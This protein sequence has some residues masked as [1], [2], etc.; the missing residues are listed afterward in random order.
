MD[1][2]GLTRPSDEA[3]QKARILLEKLDLPHHVDE[4]GFLVATGKIILRPNGIE[5][6]CRRLLRY[7]DL[8][9]PDF[10]AIVLDGDFSFDNIRRKNLEGSPL[11]VSGFLIAKQCGL[12]SLAGAPRRVGLCFWVQTNVLKNLI[13][14]P[15]M[16][17]R[18]YRC[19]SNLLESLGGAPA[20]VGSFNCEDNRLQN[21]RY[22]PRT[23]NG[24]F[25]CS[26]NDIETLV[27]GPERVNKHYQ[28]FNNPRLKLLLGVPR[29]IGGALMAT[30]TTLS[31]LR[32]AP[33][34]FM[35]L[36]TPLGSFSRW[37]DIP[38]GL[39][40]DETIC[41]AARE[42]AQRPS[43]EGLARNGM[44]EAIVATG[45][46]EDLSGSLQ[47]R[48]QK[49]DP[50]LITDEVIAEI[51]AAG[52]MGE[53]LQPHTLPLSAFPGIFDRIGAIGIALDGSAQESREHIERLLAAREVGA[54][55]AR[56]ARNRAP[57]PSL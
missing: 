13:G 34:T 1:T 41:E 29:A 51:H 24:D 47:K 11:A 40:F 23:V 39:R 17:G 37:Q 35:R 27:G 31:S 19:D 52:Q 6:D 22:A 8:P 21:I 44:L 50:A 25:D 30:N 55:R 43:P 33:R 48:G 9:D 36:D 28:C 20:Q 5:I 32:H 14:G 45:F 4:N 56:M 2:K 53:L 12:E 26:N 10:S 42:T 57:A 7:D 46:F 16:V 38:P 18:E 54:H 15:E 3:T 49:L